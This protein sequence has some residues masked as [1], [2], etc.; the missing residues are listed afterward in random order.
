MLT[1]EELQISGKSYINK[2]FQTIYPE[3]IELFKKLTN[4]IDPEATNESDPLI[5]LLKLLGFMGDKLNYNV[6]KN[7]LEAFLPSATQETSV[8]QLLETNG[9]T[10][11]Y[12]QSAS[13]TISLLYQGELSES[14]SIYLKAFDT[15]F[16]D[17]NTSII[18][19]LLED[20]LIEDG[21]V[22]KTGLITEGTPKDLA[23]NGNTSIQ[24]SNLDENYRLYFPE[25]MIAQNRIYVKNEGSNDWNTSGTSGDGW[26]QVDNLNLYSPKSKNFKFGFDSNKNL[27]YIQFP[28]DIIELIGNGLN[29]KYI[30]TIGAGGNVSRGRL[31]VL[32]N[33]TSDTLYYYN[34][35]NYTDENVVLNDE[36][37]NQYLLRVFNY[38][39]ST[40]GADPE[41][42]NEAYNNYKKTIGTFDT[43]V[44][45]RDFANW[46]YRYTDPKTTY[47]IIN[48]I[49]VSDRRIDTTFYQPYIT[50]NEFGATTDYEKISNE[51]RQDITP[52]DL[53]LYPLKKVNTYS[54]YDK[55]G[56]L[57]SD[58]YDA[59]FTP[60]SNIQDLIYALQDSQSIDHTY[61]RV[62]DSEPYLYKN[63]YNLNI[64]VSTID[65]VNEV[66][67][68]L[69]VNNIRQALFDNFNSREVDYG[70]EIPVD[71]LYNV[72]LNADT[73]I[74]NVFLDDP[75]IQT[76]VMLGNGDTEEPLIESVDIDGTVT[77]GDYYVDMIARNVLAGRVN[78]Y[79][80]LD[81]FNFNYTMSNPTLIKDVIS[82]TPTLKIIGDNNEFTLQPN[83]VVQV[84]SDSYSTSQTATVGVN[85]YWNSTNTLEANKP[86]KIVSGE[87]L[88]LSYTNSDN[89][90][91]TYK[92]EEDKISTLDENGL[93][94]SVESVDANI[95]EPTFSLT[96]TSNMGTVTVDSDMVGDPKFLQLST[97]QEIKF[98][99]K[100]EKVFND[101]KYYFYWKMNNS[102]N[103]LFDENVDEI[104][105][106]E[107]EYLMYTDMSKSGV[108]IFSAGTKVTKSGFD[109]VNDWSC[110]PTDTSE[111]VDGDLSTYA[112]IDWKLLQFSEE[113]II[114][115][116]QQT[117]ITLTNGDSIKYNANIDE[118]LESITDTFNYKFL[119]GDFVPLTNDSLLNYRVR[120]RLDVVCGPEL[121]QTLVTNDK[122]EEKIA[123]VDSESHSDTLEDIS[124][125]S[126]Y[127][128]Q[129]SGNGT[130]DTQLEGAE[131]NIVKYTQV[132]EPSGDGII[133]Q[134]S[135]YKV[136]F[137]NLGT[138]PYILTL[139]VPRVSGC[140]SDFMIYFKKDGNTDS[141]SVSGAN[142]SQLNDGV[143]MLSASD[144][145]VVLTITSSNSSNSFIVIDEIKVISG[146]NSIFKLDVN[147]QSN[148]LTKIAK[149][150]LFYSTYNIPY[151]KVIDIE[152]FTKPEVMWDKNNV[153]NKFTLP[154]IDFSVTKIDVLKSSLK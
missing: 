126:N 65:K 13:T 31:T 85:Y 1:N 39:A 32:N 11:R 38:Y 56:N 76:K 96:P 130:I 142:I 152:D 104:I 47:P 10:K 84:F 14:K 100:N 8:R 18:Y 88:Y 66:E 131:F 35:L 116:T 81:N 43:L 124:I 25:T 20:I 117:I 95:I 108:E 64:K 37:N 40:N 99:R 74:K 153:L 26:T 21:Q 4:V 5:V 101:G 146:V 69:I 136:E 62:A 91:R 67:R 52:F 49:Q 147:L 133:K 51:N 45:C 19:T 12:Y 75:E 54:L 122:Y 33:P 57:K 24:L 86:H 29:V 73:R 121:T 23:I 145:A 36:V 98:L 41:T 48:N 107:D 115:L 114:S 103:I 128:I 148:L 110:T 27:P 61:I 6:D 141:V 9:Y 80:Y 89:I 102:K 149:Y 82:L 83:Q 3:L 132:K 111:L 77:N 138:Y 109:N 90:K 87:A 2:D 93:I 16:T 113:D 118:D 140:T 15:Q 60:S 150:P 151:S 68:K 125:F 17:E 120:T 119:G 59:T 92:Y 143:N 137:K 42:I 44:T 144:D 112:G 105:L 58:N 127:L 123:Y 63:Y 30:V 154:Q 72:I 78:L 139:N 106:G 46:L 70:Y 97:S 79:Q 50:Y 94:I 7:I 135:Q 34:G 53:V 55:N 22:T 28:D 134:G 129:R 71:T